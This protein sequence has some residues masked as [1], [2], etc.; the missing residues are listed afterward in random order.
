MTLKT[1]VADILETLGRVTG[2]MEAEN[3]PLSFRPTSYPDPDG[4]K[5]AVVRIR[6]EERGGTPSVMF[7]I[8]V[9]SYCEDMDVNQFRRELNGWASVVRFGSVLV[10]GYDMAGTG[11]GEGKIVV[12]HSMTEGE[13][14]PESMAAVLGDVLA[15]WQK[16]HR[17]HRQLKVRHRAE[18]RSTQVR[19]MRPGQATGQARREAT[20]TRGQLDR[21][22]GLAPVKLFVRQQVALHRVRALRKDAGLVATSVS[23]HLVFTG[24]PGTG[25]TTVAKIVAR[26]YKDLGLVSKGHVVVA[27]RADLVANYVGQTAGKTRKICESAKGGVLFIDEAYSLSTRH[28]HHDYGREVIETLITFMEENRDDFA[29]VVAGYPEEMGAFIASNPGLASRFDRTVEFPDYSDLEMMEILGL[30][31]KEEDFE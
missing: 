8:Y 29:V 3:H 31:M 6:F 18:A 27:E 19:T 16:S 4:P 23:P 1:T 12:R 30:M 17:T 7:H 5:G 11:I 24:N 21:L 22:I 2:T 10:M 13:I 9:G 14:S 26:M 15:L 20:D 28:E 25:K